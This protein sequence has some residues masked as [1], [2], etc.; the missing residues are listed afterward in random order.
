MKT[1]TSDAGISLLFN[2]GFESIEISLRDFS[3]MIV[4]CVAARIS[5]KIMLLKR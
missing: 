5:E 1:E 2:I 3:E 4:R